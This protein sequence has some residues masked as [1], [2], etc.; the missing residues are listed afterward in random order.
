MGHGV[1][2]CATCDGFYKNKIVAVVGGGN[3][4]E[5]AFFYLIFVKRLF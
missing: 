2:A 4:T 1:S 5:E 3:I